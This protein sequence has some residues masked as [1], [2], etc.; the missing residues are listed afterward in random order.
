[1]KISKFIN[2]LKKIPVSGCAVE[3]LTNVGRTCEVR[4]ESFLGN[5]I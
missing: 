5:D 3:V 2:V 1:M 4:F